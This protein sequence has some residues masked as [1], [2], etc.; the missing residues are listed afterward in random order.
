M[1][2]AAA[3]AGLIG[4]TQATEALKF[5]LFGL[6]N[7]LSCLRYQVD[8]VKNTIGEQRR[9][10]ENIKNKEHRHGQNQ[11]HRNQL[12]RLLHLVPISNFSWRH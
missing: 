7:I 10:A 8:Q 1:I 3:E 4:I 12:L 6:S 11:I 5:L 2:V 9:R